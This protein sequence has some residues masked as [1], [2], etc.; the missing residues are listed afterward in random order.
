MKKLIIIVFIFMI[1]G[2]SAK[3]SDG[4]LSDF[5]RETGEK[6]SV[7]SLTIEEKN[8]LLILRQDYFQELKDIQE[9][10]KNLRKEANECMVNNDEKRYEEI[11]DKM[12]ELKLKRELVKENHKKKVNEILKK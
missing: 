3:D 8:E 7:E 12:N 9:N 4:F 1:Y 10:M 2:L 5:F 6:K 11:H